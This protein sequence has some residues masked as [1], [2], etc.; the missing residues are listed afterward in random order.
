MEELVKLVS[1]KTGLPADQAKAADADTLLLACTH[2][3]LLLPRIR[4]LIPPGVT[5]CSQDEIVAPSL[6]DVF[7]SLLSET[8]TP[9]PSVPQP[10]TGS[11]AEVHDG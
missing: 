5:I 9:D 3:P 6:E 7:V 8:S 4:A 11:T 2:Y 1:A 10:S